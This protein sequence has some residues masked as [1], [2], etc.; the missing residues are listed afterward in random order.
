MLANKIYLLTPSQ[1]I[2]GLYQSKIFDAGNLFYNAQFYGEQF[3]IERSIN[4]QLETLYQ[5]SFQRVEKDGNLYLL[6]DDYTGTTLL[7][8]LGHE[9][10][11]FYDSTQSVVANLELKIPLA[12]SS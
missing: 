7:I 1:H 10:F 2:N 6:K 3:Y 5:G 4:Q 9:Q 8:V 12:A 11:Y